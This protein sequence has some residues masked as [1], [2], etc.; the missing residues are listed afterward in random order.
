MTKTK[1]F[2]KSIRQVIIIAFVRAFTESTKK[3]TKAKEARYKK[4]N[5]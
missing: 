4:P 3:T 1:K 2:K 5:F